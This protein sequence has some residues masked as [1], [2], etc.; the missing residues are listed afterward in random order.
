MY[1][2]F[3]FGSTLTMILSKRKKKRRRKKEKKTKVATLH[4]TTRR[5]NDKLTK[6]ANIFSP[7]FPRGKIFA[8][9]YFIHKALPSPPPD[10]IFRGFVDATGFT[11]IFRIT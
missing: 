8:A 7:L 11:V 5:M 2:A 3:P 9:G 1:L 6:F 10:V 4:T